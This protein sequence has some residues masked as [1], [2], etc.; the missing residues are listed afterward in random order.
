MKK[1]LY[2]KPMFCDSGGKRYRVVY[3]CKWLGYDFIFA[4]P[5]DKKEI[6]DKEVAFFQ[7]RD[8]R[9][10][11]VLCGFVVDADELDAL[12]SGFNALRRLNQCGFT[13]TIQGRKV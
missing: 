12:A 6:K 11:K 13:K 7:Y 5:L 9:K 3:W 4:I 2:D 1:L 8:R 10:K